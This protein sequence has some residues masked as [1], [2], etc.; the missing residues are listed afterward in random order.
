MARELKEDV[1]SGQGVFPSTSTSSEKQPPSS[2]SSSSSLLPNVNA[3][4]FMALRE[5]IRKS[6]DVGNV[7]KFMLLGSIMGAVYGWT[8]RSIDIKN[9]EVV[10]EPKA[11]Y[12]GNE[13]SLSKYFEELAQFRIAN[14]TDYCES[15]RCADRILMIETQI[16]SS[17]QVAETHAMLAEMYYKSARMHLY[18][19][20]VSINNGKD[21][22]KAKALI[23][24]IAQLLQTHLTRINKMTAPTR[25]LYAFGRLGL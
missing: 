14:E 23:K 18:Q 25:S 5:K 2:S 4:D 15:I 12:F 9:D 1:A 21:Q 11:H 16:A 22:A 24:Q 7:A 10:L 20:S 13:P 6:E 19:F 3:V 17:K 8:K